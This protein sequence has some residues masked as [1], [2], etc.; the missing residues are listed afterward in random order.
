[1]SNLENSVHISNLPFQVTRDDVLGF[2]QKQDNADG[3]E[4][5]DMPNHR[6]TSNNRG[7]CNVKLPSSDQAISFIKS[8]NDIDF[9]GRTLRAE[10]MKV[11]ERKE[12]SE[13]P[14][15]SRP[16]RTQSRA[17]RATPDI[18][19][20]AHFNGI[21]YTATK[22]DMI[23]Y[24]RQ[25][26]DKTA[27][28]YI[29]RFPMKDRVHNKGFC[30][31]SFKSQEQLNQVIEDLNGAEIFGRQVYVSQTDISRVSPP[32]NN[33]PPKVHTS[34]YPNQEKSLPREESEQENSQSPEQEN[35]QSPEQENSQPREEDVNNEQENNDE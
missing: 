9:N 4:I 13:R 7:Y 23:R 33:K 1:M 29:W 3:V 15:E 17:P 6:N 27:G 35:S 19:F 10:K 31:V 11:I 20:S 30:D 14:T 26:E 21:D 16:R 24:L 5:V 34:K 18:K 25:G 8:I 2:L 32:R 28:F 12:Q 22:M